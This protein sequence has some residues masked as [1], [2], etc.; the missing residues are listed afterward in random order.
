MVSFSLAA[1]VCPALAA[2]ERRLSLGEI[3]VTSTAVEHFKEKQIRLEAVI[4]AAP[5]RVWGIVSDCAN[6]KTTMPTIS[7]SEELSHEGNVVV[8]RST[9]DLQWPLPNLDATTRVVQ[10]VGDGRWTADWTLVSGDYKYNQGSWNLTT[11]QAD[12]TRTLVVYEVLVAPKIAVPA[13]LELFGKTRALPNMIRGLRTQL[14]VS[15][16]G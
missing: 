6:F 3:I 16:A 1:L 13:A 5:E 9:L 15:V 4:N 7:A 2:D 12:P 8:C 14:G 11:F 10:I